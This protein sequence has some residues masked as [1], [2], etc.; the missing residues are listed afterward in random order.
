MN[1][2]LAILGTTLFMNTLDMHVIAI[3]AKSGRELW[4]TKMFD[5]TAAGGY[6]A[7]GAP[8]IV[9]DKLIVG[10][11]GGERG[12]SGFLDAYDPKTGAA[13]SGAS[14]R[15][16]SPANRT[17]ATWAGDSWKT[18][19]VST[20]NTGAYDPDT[21]T[22]FWGTSN[23]WPDYIDDIRAGDNLYSGSVLAL[24]PDTGK[25]KW[26]YQFTP[27]DTHDWDSTQNP[28]L[29]DTDV[30]RTAAQG[31]GL[32]EPQRVLLSDRPH[33]RKIPVRHGVREADMERRL[34]LREQRPAES[35]ARHGTDSR[36]QRSRSGRASTAARTGWPTAT[37]R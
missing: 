18:G 19:G 24:D 12:V 29:V 16:R 34:R 9:K 8:L 32:A 25:L 35:R 20:W 14:T 21:N 28:V 36:R 3:D 27:H 23:P 6:A 13:S 11:A 4:K 17:S 1:R 26:H 5:Y 15:F 22:L 31:A 7:T 33:Q 37:A 2:G 10:M 30:S